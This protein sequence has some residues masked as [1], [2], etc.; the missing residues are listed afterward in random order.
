VRHG[1]HGLTRERVPKLLA[2]LEP[3]K[4]L[5]VWHVATERE[6]WQTTLSIP[7]GYP[8]A[9]RVQFAD[10][11]RIVVARTENDEPVAIVEATSARPVAPAPPL[12]AQLPAFSVDGKLLA[13]IALDDLGRRTVRVAQRENANVLASSHA[14]SAPSVLAFDDSG[15]LLAAGGQGTLCILEVP[16]LRLLNRVSVLGPPSD[17]P[18]AVVTPTFVAGGRAVFVS[19]E[20]GQSTLL[21]FP[22]LSTVWSGPGILIRGE[23]P[24]IALKTDGTT[25]SE[26]GLR[27]V[28]RTRGA[29][30]DE[31]LWLQGRG[32]GAGPVL[33]KASRIKI[34][35]SYCCTAF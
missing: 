28:E 31:L 23:L 25:V 34:E 7:A 29:A 21:S 8:L 1:A 15:R 33:E 16:S 4:T 26:I 3:P 13:Y 11:G 9:S 27:G 22:T 12:G 17:A 18:S 19:R 6:L 20:D 32:D 14:C 35:R 30:D 24:V 2:I 10:R 5:R